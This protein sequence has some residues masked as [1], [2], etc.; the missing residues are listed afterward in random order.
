M[1]LHCNTFMIFIFSQFTTSSCKKDIDF[2]ERFKM[3]HSNHKITTAV[4]FMI[5]RY[6]HCLSE[7]DLTKNEIH[8][9]LFPSARLV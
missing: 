7:L 6:L 2:V 9:S 3:S 8:C 4:C 5:N 1:R